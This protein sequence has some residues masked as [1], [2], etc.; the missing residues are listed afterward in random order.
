MKEIDWKNRVTALLAWTG[1]KSRTF[2]RVLW[3]VMAVIGRTLGRVVT[4]W[5]GR[6][7]DW[8]RHHPRE[9]LGAGSVIGLCLVL[10]V[11]LRPADIRT[12][13]LRAELDCL[14]LNIYHEARGEPADGMIAVGQVVM[15]RVA[16]ARFP[17]SVCAVVQQ[18]G[19][20]ELHRCQFS[21]WCDGR[22]D[23]PKEAGAFEM[24]ES[25]ARKL[26]AGALDDPT[27]GALW[28]HAD[29]VAP[30]WRNDFAEGPT[31]G[32]H[33]FYRAK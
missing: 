1:R 25:L 2:V 14:A 32:Q 28:Y 7:G 4:W 24:S 19:E 8:A 31:I 33:I 5:V 20:T 9:A 11:I 3:R 23:Q 18:G 6:V 13:D 22:S 29:Y 16:D 12:V 10:I 21:W 26:L 15:N 17:G 30:E 27:G